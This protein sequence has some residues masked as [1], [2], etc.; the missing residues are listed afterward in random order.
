VRRLGRKLQSDRHGHEP[1]YLPVAGDVG[2]TLKVE[3][4][5]T[6]AGGSG[7]R[8]PR[9]PRG[10]AGNKTFGKTAMVLAGHLRLRT[11]RV[12]SYALPEAGSVTKLTMYLAPTAKRANRS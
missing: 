8:S 2:H 12:N 7:G 6:N 3:E 5:A 9:A 1:T 10:R 4:T 11:Q